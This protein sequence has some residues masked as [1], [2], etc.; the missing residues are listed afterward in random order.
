MTETYDAKSRG[1]P[2]AELLAHPTATPTIETTPAASGWRR[3]RGRVAVVVV[4]ILVAAA[5]AV[6]DAVVAAAAVLAGT[7]VVATGDAVVAII[8]S[9]V[10]D[11]VFV[12]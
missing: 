9:W 4:V 6:G 7:V 12:P 10:V 2:A 8:A 1:D 3:A 11:V 5:A